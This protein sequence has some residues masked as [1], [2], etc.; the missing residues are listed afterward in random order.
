MVKAAILLLLA[1]LTGCATP[2][3]DGILG[4][5]PTYL[6][7][8]SNDVPNLGAL[9]NRIWTPALDEGFV[10]QGLTSSGAFL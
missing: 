8:P 2:R 6:E 4:T 3:A 9:G 7:S 1:V 5:R 10:P